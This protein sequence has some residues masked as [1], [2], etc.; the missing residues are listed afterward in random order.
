MCLGLREVVFRPN[1][2]GRREYIPI[3]D[4]SIMHL[5]LDWKA[6][7][8]SSNRKVIMHLSL[9]WKVIMLQA[10]VIDVHLF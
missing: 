5:S 6:F 4:V 7:N 1:K 3:E 9:D 10:T 2:P 8:F